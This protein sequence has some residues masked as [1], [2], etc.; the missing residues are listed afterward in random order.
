MG[1]VC[2]LGEFVVMRVYVGVGLSLVVFVVRLGLS[3]GWVCRWGGF[4]VRWVCRWDGFVVGRV[5]LTWVR[6]CT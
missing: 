3:L 5:C 1:W 4:V 2:R 6:R